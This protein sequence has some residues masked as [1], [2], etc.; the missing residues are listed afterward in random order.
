MKS[1]IAVALASLAFAYSAMAAPTIGDADVTDVTLNGSPAD[2]IAFSLENGQAGPDGN[3]SVFVDEFGGT[4]DLL[5]KVDSGGNFDPTSTVINGTTITY[6]FSLDP[7]GTSGTWSLTS[8]TDMMLDLAFAMHA[9]GA[10]ASY[11]FDDES[12]VAGVTSNGTFQI[13]WLNN[14]GQVPT[15]SNLTLFQDSVSVIPEPETYAMM[16]GGL[17]LIGF[18][19]RRRK[20]SGAGAAHA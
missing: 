18:L 6:G 9:G 4:W 20:N 3:S 7:G 8:S 16:L 1:R 14:G 17:G 15:Y 13:E 10:T 2:D 12:L 11:L 19:N 5:T